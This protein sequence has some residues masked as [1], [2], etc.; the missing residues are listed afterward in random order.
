[1]KHEILEEVWR[2]REQIAAECGY[3]VDRLFERIR[4]LE[5]RDKDRVVQPPP[6]RAP[7]ESAALR[8]E[9]TPYDANPAR[10]SENPIEEVWRIRDEMSAEYGHDVHRMFEA[11]REK[12]KEYGD[13]VVHRVPRRVTEESAPVPRE[14]PPKAE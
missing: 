5:A 2:I 11:M 7:M 1:M 14:E 4:A 6:R 8:E 3:D 10:Q 12:E 9:P 13:R